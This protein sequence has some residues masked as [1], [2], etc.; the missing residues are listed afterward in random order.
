MSVETL[1]TKPSLSGI[2]KNGAIAGGAAVVVNAVLYLVSN[3]LG[4][5]PADVLSPM[6]TP[7][8][9]APVIGMTVFGAVAGT[10]GYLV[11]SRFLSRAQANRWFTILAVLVLV[12]MTTTPLGLSGAPL[13]QIVML[14]VMHLVIGIALIYY[15]PKSA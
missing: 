11:L 5:F 8:T 15:L 13:M 6:G 1:Q 4:W 2:L 3:A 14:E 10:V 7:I 9:L 12:L